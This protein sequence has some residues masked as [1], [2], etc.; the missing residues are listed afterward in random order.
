MPRG[1]AIPEVREQLFQAA[2]RVLFRSG[3][4]GFSS[5]AIAQE[6]G[7][8]KGLLFNHFTDL[9]QFLAELVLDRARTAGRETTAL[10]AK[11]G[12]GDVAAN[13]ADSAASLLRSPVFAIAAIVHSRPS[14]MARLHELGPGRPFHLL[15]DVEK[16]FGDYL[17]AE[18]T[19]G[20]IA[21]EV[22]TETLAMSLVGTL[23]YGFVTGRVDESNAREHVQRIVGCLGATAGFQP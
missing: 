18:K 22:D 17:E 2:E 23:H 21:A 15:G 1:V 8:A 11:A 14:I 16:A 9:D 5:R 3:A 13:L 4:E 10:T 19:A 12:S 20:R 6:A 7:V